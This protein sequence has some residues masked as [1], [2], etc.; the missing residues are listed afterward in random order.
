MDSRGRLY[1]LGSAVSVSSDS[2]T[3]LDSV[4]LLRYDP[5]G[6]ALDTLATLMVAKLD[7]KVEQVGGKIRSVSLRRVPLMA[8]DDWTL[9]ADDRVAVVRTGEYRLDIVGTGRRL[10]RGSRIPYT[11]I[12][13]NDLDRKAAPAWAQL[14]KVKPPFDGPST[15]ASSD[16][17]IWI[18]RTAAAGDSI[19]HYDVLDLAGRR[20]WSK[21]QPQE[22]RTGTLQ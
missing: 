4:P 19:P 3:P 16:R 15:L 6:E 17:R 8:H 18:R 1:F 9:L 2:P 11:P 5:A 21:G 22:H 13:V 7:M 12:P 10:V 14:P 20:A